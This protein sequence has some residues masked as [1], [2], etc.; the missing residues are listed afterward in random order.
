MSNDELQGLL[1]EALLKITVLNQVEAKAAIDFLCKF[2]NQVEDK[3]SN[4]AVE[5]Q[6]DARIKGPYGATRWVVL[7]T[8]E[9]GSDYID[10]EV[11]EWQASATSC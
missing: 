6:V 1:S 2:V 11:G 8:E 9:Y 3:I 5:Y 7:N 4:I 10:F